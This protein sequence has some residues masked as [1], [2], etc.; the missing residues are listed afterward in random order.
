MALKMGSLKFR[1]S[2]SLPG[3]VSSM[4]Y[5]QTCYRGIALAYANEQLA[6][7]QADAIVRPLIGLR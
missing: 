7:G 4:L 2:N 3:C 1:L 6:L 5:Q